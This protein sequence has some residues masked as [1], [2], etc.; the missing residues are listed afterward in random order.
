MRKLVSILD[1]ISIWIGKVAAWVIL[2]V[3]A[4]I[5]Y[6]IVMRYVF[7]RPTI[8]VT[9]TM[10]FGCGL[11]YVLCSAWT[12][13]DGRHVRIDM[14]YER[15]SPRG[16]ATFDSITFFAF[17]LYM[18]MLGWAMSK[19]AYRSVII[20]EESDSPWRPALWPMK[21]ALTAGVFTILLQ[22]IANFIRD[23]YFAITGKKL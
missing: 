1:S 12:T 14:V 16:R 11:I 4:V 8:W 21:V 7:G 18:V 15:L 20:W 5:T 2:P 9:E 22:G 6:E 13:Q 23:V 10:I 3:I 17:L 19:Y